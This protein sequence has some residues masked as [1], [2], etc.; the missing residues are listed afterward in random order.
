M[1]HPAEET[2]CPSGHY[3]EQGVVEPVE[4]PTGTF[5][6]DEGRIQEDDCTPCPPGFICPRGADEPQECPEGYYCIIGSNEKTPCPV[7]TYSSVEKLIVESEC[8]SCPAGYFC[9]DEAQINYKDYLCSAGY[10]CPQR[11]EKEIACPAGTYRDSVGAKSLDDC[12]LCPSGYYC[13]EATASPIQCS[14][15]H[16]C[17]YGS[18]EMRLCPGGYYCNE[19][20]NY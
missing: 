13:P 12:E 8:L 11:T 7:G 20:N 19:E 14:D 15:G 6:A 10:Y 17:P 2:I 5:S 16:Y 9:T 18:I 1:S 4:C 3:C